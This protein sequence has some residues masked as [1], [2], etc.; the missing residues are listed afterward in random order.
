LS[1]QVCPLG[2]ERQPIRAAQIAA[3]ETS[4]R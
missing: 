1:A 2:D 3:G 4:E